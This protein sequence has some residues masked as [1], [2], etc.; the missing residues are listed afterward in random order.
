MQRA[1]AADD[2]FVRAVA[3]APDAFPIFDAATV[4]EIRTRY[5]RAKEPDTVAELEQQRAAIQLAEAN[6]QSA[7]RTLGGLLLP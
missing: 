7:R 6:T 3:R 5:A 2:A 1:E 4:T